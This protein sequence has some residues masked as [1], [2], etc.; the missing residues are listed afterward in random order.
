[1][2]KKFSRH[3]QHQETITTAAA[4]KELS[5]S[6]FRRKKKKVVTSKSIP[7]AICELRKQEGKAIPPTI[8][9]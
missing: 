2:E 7:K 5:P 3:S 6:T 8:V 1:V 4:K 9:S